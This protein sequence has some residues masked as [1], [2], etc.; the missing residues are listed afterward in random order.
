MTFGN[1]ET[2]TP[3]TNP[4]TEPGAGNLPKIVLTAAEGAR[5][6]IYLHGAHLTSWVPAGGTE[7]LFLSPK[8][9]FRPGLAIRGGVPVIF[10]QFGGMGPLPKHGFARTSDWELADSAPGQAVL[11]LQES[12]SSLAAWPHKFKLEYTVRIGGS[13]LEMTLKVSNTGGTPFEFTAALHTY[14][15]VADLRHTTAWGLKGLWLKDNA[16]A[17]H[18]AIQKDEWLAFPGEVDRIYFKAANPVQV[19]Q[20]QQKT[21]LEQAGFT[22]VVAWN[23]GPDKCL[24]L[25]DMQ[26]DG[27]LEFVCVEA[28]VVETP[29]R[30]GPGGSWAGTQKLTVQT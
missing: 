29:V 26:P 5:A 12:Q 3:T 25:E 27:Y 15:R 16:S 4:T 21:S 10:P 23:P 19:V 14:L 9:D 17:G 7:A 24:T 20:E 8:A 11:R 22:D 13:R 30:L 1:E 6:E 2:M 28:A 18:E